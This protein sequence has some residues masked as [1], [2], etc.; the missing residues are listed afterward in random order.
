MRM[1]LQEGERQDE[2]S[3]DTWQVV[4]HGDPLDDRGHSV[5]GEVTSKSASMK[6]LQYL[7]DSLEIVIDSTPARVDELADALWAR[8]LII[9]TN[10]AHCVTLLVWA[11]QKNLSRNTACCF[12]T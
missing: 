11:Q 10:D 7:P 12:R 8:K 5:L 4:L 3:W 1:R 6:R 9:V 2:L